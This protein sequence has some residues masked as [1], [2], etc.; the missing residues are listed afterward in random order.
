MVR[1]AAVMAGNATNR[2]KRW[3][4]GNE[5]V[6]KQQAKAIR[7]RGNRRLQL[8]TGSK[9]VVSSRS[10]CDAAVGVVLGTIAL[11]KSQIRGKL[12]RRKDQQS[13]EARSGY[14]EFEKST[15]PKLMVWTKTRRYLEGG[16]SRGT[17]LGTSS[18]DSR[19]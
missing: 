17:G 13:A 3:L 5:S 11:S 18:D 10:T 2:R 19:K 4:V 9:T 16:A 8:L 7:W 1:K 14:G 15:H 6:W 12:L